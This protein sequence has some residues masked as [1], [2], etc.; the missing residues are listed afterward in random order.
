MKG[1]RGVI[2]FRGSP[3]FA[4]CGSVLC[5]LILGWF[6]GMSSC[7]R[8]ILHID[9]DCFYCKFEMFAKFD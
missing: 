4:F 8:V 5:S 1:T 3:N 7:H 6:G 9:L 2:D